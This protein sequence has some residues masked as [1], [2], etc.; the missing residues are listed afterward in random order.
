[1]IAA[2]AAT[3]WFAAAARVVEAS[4]IAHYSLSGALLPA[5][6]S[7]DPRRREGNLTAVARRTLLESWKA[8]TGFSIAAALA[9]TVMAEPLSRL[10]FGDGFGPT[11]GALRVLSWALIPFSLNAFFSVT[12]IAAGAERPPLL[13]VTTGILVF[14]ALGALWIPRIG[15]MAAGWSAV[16]AECSQV[17]VYLI[18]RRAARNRR[19]FDREE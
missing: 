11:A 19:Q 14:A 9:I 13:A 10:L 18:F 17:V 15:L 1:L 6:G 16:I 5:L 2:P 8:L 4:K 3:G 7:A 12:Y